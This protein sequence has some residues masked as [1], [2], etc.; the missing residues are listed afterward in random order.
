MGQGHGEG[1]SASYEDNGLQEGTDETPNTNSRGGTTG[2]VGRVIAVANQKGGVAK[3]TTTLHL[4]AALADMG[5]RVLLIDLDPQG[6]L[7]LSCGFQPDELEQT[8]YDALVKDVDPTSLR[9]RT[10]FGADLLPANIDLALADIELVNLMA[11]ERRL[12]R[13]LAPLRD[14]Y[15]FVLMDCQPSLGL[16]T[17]NALAACDDVLVPV[18]CEFL[19]VRA[20]RALFK[21][22]GKV[23][24]R[25]NSRLRVIGL[26]P[27][28][29]DLRTNHSKQVLQ[30]LVEAFQGRVPIFDTP[31][32]RSIR[33]P[34]AAAAGRPIF[35][36]APG[37]PGDEAYRRL[38]QA[39]L[40]DELAPSR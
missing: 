18:A 13:L 8:V 37:H 10:P 9:L 1:G 33:F 27:T 17:V 20:L 22:I 11:R 15:D 32:R 28:M 6:G 40:N 38:A 30:E 4:G 14:E 36:H 29:Y 7:T 31:V 19:S 24:L 3:T 12:G 35:T 16:V 34:E 25:L 21:V 23:R 26:V 2:A 39:V 5:Q